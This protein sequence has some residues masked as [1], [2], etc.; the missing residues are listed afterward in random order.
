VKEALGIKGDEGPVI[1]LGGEGHHARHDYGLWAA[2]ILRQ[3][4]PLTRV[5]V[6]DDPRGQLDAGL[7][8]LQKALPEEGML[9]VAP[10]EMTWPELLRAA[11]IF[12][13]TPD[14]PM[15]TGTILQAMA[16]GVPVI[17]TPVECVTELIA[18][19]HTGLLAK[20]V[21]PRMIAARLEEFMNDGTMK[22]PLIDK[23][24]AEV[25]AQYR[26]SVML[27]GYAALYNAGSLMAAGAAAAGA[28]T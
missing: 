28:S 19:G 22:W 6:R 25:Y 5:V 16:A 15:Q 24:R 20:A 12:L 17:G 26:P 21:K 2:A 9:S 13:V 4:F 18:Q 27:E 3:I 11:D 1:L 8:R 10:A 23:A 7:D 14:G